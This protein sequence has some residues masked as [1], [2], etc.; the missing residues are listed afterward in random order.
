MLTYN[1][2]DEK[3]ESNDVKKLMMKT[4]NNMCGL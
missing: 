1:K 4:M 3:D 2:N